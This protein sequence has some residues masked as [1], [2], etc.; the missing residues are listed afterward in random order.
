[1]RRRPVPPCPQRLSPEE[2]AGAKERDAAIAHYAS[3]TGDPPPAFKFTVYNHDEIRDRLSDAFNGVCAYCEAPISAVEIEHFR[4]KG[5][6]Q[7][8]DRPEPPGYYWLAATWENLLPSCYYCNAGRW[9][10]APDGSRYK[11]GKAN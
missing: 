6:V 11:S 8:A 10:K 4:P 1:M 3:A 7:T 2:S 9:K 5:A